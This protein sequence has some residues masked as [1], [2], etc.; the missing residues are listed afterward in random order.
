MESI[1]HEKVTQL[2]RRS[3]DAGHKKLFRLS[4]LLMQ[5]LFCCAARG[6]SVR[7]ALSKRPSTRYLFQCRRSRQSRSSDGR[8]GKTQNGRVRRRQRGLPEIPRG[9]FIAKLI[10]HSS[11]KALI[12]TVACFQQPSGNM[13]DSGY[14][15]VQ[16]ISSALKVWGLELIP[17]NGTEPMALVAQNNPS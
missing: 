7:S 5:T 11:P 8:G 1:F 4:A 3:Y 6:V 16:V 17:Y 15:S 13:D 2:Y 12:R 9:M 14:F 10:S